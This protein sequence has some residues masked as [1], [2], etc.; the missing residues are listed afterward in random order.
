MELGGGALSGIITPA[1]VAQANLSASP[2]GVGR[3]GDDSSRFAAT[4]AFREAR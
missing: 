4:A 1:T 2:G 3:L